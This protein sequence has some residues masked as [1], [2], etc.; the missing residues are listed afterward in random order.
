MSLDRPTTD[1]I[2][3][4][5]LLEFEKTVQPEIQSERAR[6]IGTMIAYLLQ[7]LITRER[8]GHAILKRTLPVEV[9]HLRQA[10][11]ILGDSRLTELA[12]QLTLSGKDEATLNRTHERAAAALEGA[13]QAVIARDDAAAT[14]RRRAFVA[15]LLASEI[16]FID[17]IDPP[18]LAPGSAYTAALRAADSIDADALN[19]YFEATGRFAGGNVIA[20]RVDRLQGGFSKDTFI[21]TLCGAGRPADQIVIR[22]DAPSGPIDASVV[23]EFPVIAGL[24]RGRFPVA[25]PLWLEAD[26]GHFGSAFLVTK[27]VPGAAPL[28]PD[29]VTLM[30]GPEDGA[31]AARQFARLLARF[32]ATNLVDLGYSAQDARIPAATHVLRQVNEFEEYWRP[33]KSAPEPAMAAA[34]AWL[35][36][37]VPKIVAGPS[38]VHGDASLR[39]LLMHEGK[40]SALLDW[41]TV[42]IG[43]PC[44]DLS[45]VRRDIELVLPWDQFLAE[46]YAAGGAEY[47]Q[48]NARFFE[49][50]AS[51]RNGAYSLAHGFESAPVPDIRFGFSSAYYHR[52]FLRNI[53]RFLTQYN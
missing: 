45:Y 25:E 15:S 31:H 12:E 38:A 27:R 21:A 11:S 22:R 4:S 5:I 47:R 9:D 43:D 16:N 23:A 10:A 18:K 33:R 37:N 39:N 1:R 30:V 32:H 36:R 53:T 13:V 24:F 50:W 40:I 52:E 2:R 41:E 6:F 26:D 29:G 7:S 34:F 20:E 35:R 44:E 51:V 19:R 3:T 8:D 28:H 49:L 46:Y 17:A 48:E 42:H 14:P